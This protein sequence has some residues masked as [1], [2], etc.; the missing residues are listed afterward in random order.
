MAF[1]Q[2]INEL[3]AED[4]SG[5]LS[6]HESWQ[7]VPL[8]YVVEVI[9]GYAFPSTGFNTGKGLPLIRIRDIVSGKTNTTF[10][11][12]FS[13]DY[14]VNNGD[15]LIG[16]DGDFNTDFWR[17]GAALLNQ[18]V[19]KLTA[20]ENFYNQ[21]FLA[22]L[23]PGYLNSIH[24]K[25]S[26]VTVKHLS[27]KTIQSIPLPLPTK[28]EQDRLVEKLEELFSEFDAG[29]K[30]LE[31]AQVK[32]TQYRQS[33]LKSAVEG[34]LT[35]KWRETENHS[36]QETGEQLLERI[37]IE[38]REQW[39]QKKLEDF[40]AKNK[41]PPKG[42][43]EKYPE[44]IQP[45]T[46]DLP[47]LPEGWVW[48]SL[49]QCFKVE[50][51][52][53]PSRKQPSYWE[54]NIPWASSG[55]VQFGRVKDT[56]EK[57]TEEGLNNS[58]TQI[59]PKGSVLLGMIGEGKTRGQSAIL[60]IDAANNQNCAALWVPDSGISSEYVFY[61]LWSQ[62]EKTRSGS[63]G[64]NQPA[65]NKSLVEK[66]P[67]AISSLKEMAFIGDYLSN[68]F[69]MAEK[70]SSDISFAI[71]QSD[72][73]RKNI[74][75]S[76]F[77]GQ[78]VPQDPNGES[79]SVLLKK[80]KKEREALAKVAKPRTRHKSKKKGNVMSTLL[81]VLKAEDKPMDAQAAFK[82][83]GVVDGAT[84]DRIEEIY[85]E[86]RQLEKDGQVKIERDGDYDQ[87]TFIKQDVKED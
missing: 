48:A 29:V 44:P 28:K 27:S 57:I 10:E 54:G 68:E 80:I 30:E 53:T 22:Y 46:A 26:A 1:S 75:K 43:K 67:I 58:S 24:Q 70:K 6:K 14:I 71:K 39:Q 7:R 41:T 81:E 20:N 76:A 69:S 86:L 4:T 78:L 66:M 9:N 84:T 50:V 85:T 62:Y 21:K 31:V 42:W 55:E 82:K 56:K 19:C 32:L 49:G 16:M 11:G 74:L 23:L 83:C 13:E 3:V 79:A 87:L 77:S 51:G 45:D 38:R 17:S 18:R 60:D 73:Q 25:T 2:D 34:T 40:E 5:L 59:N 33:L 36:I 12:D 15:L 61:W 63:S 65:L 37:L 72:A 47:E 35:Q 64:N 8:E 52:A